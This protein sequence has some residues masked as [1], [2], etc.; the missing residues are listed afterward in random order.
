MHSR[1]A[2]ALAIAIALA[3]GACSM[4]DS[5]LAPASGAP[6]YVPG[7]AAP[8]TLSAAANILAGPI[9]QWERTQW[10]DGR[11]LVAPAPERY[12]ARFEGGGRVA[13]LADCN[14]GSAAYEVNGGAM[15]ISPAALTRIGCPAGSLDNAYASELS[16]ATDYAIASGELTLTLADGG[17]MRFRARPN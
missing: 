11:T 13:L 2:V 9:W 16:R 7:N 6:A 17:T 5:N 15:K 8:P 12:T 1:T 3:A 4:R 10:T 14:H